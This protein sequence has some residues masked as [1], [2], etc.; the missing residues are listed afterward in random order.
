MNKIVQHLYLNNNIFWHKGLI[1]E[2]HNKNLGSHRKQIIEKNHLLIL[3]LITFTFF[4]A[5]K[6]LSSSFRFFYF[7]REQNRLDGNADHVPIWVVPNCTVFSWPSNSWLSYSFDWAFLDGHRLPA[8]F[9]NE[10]F[11]GVRQ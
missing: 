11:G 4:T 8:I 5:E 6:K 2:R 1:I 7:F 9:K 3:V 10:K